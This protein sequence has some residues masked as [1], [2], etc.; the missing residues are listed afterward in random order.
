MSNRTDLAIEAVEALEQGHGIE[1]EEVSLGKTKI[2]TVHIK[3]D[4]DEQK[5]GKRKGKYITI[6]VQPFGENGGFDE[7]TH[8]AIKSEISNIV[9]KKGTVLVVGI[10]NTQITPDAFGPKTA[11]GILATRH[12]SGELAKSVGLEGLRSVAVISPGVLGRTGIESYE[13]IKGIVARIEPA[14]VICIDALAAKSLFRL[15]NTVQI[16]NTGI[17][18]GSGVGNKRAELSRESLGVDVIS[19]GVPTVVDAATIIS[20]FSGNDSNKFRD[21]DLIV[22]PREIDLMNDRAAEMVSFAINCALQPNIDPKILQG[23]V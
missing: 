2:T 14:C 4:S 6:Q 20:E 13:I 18:P 22:T 8:S 1:T 12:I 21:I 10:G 16:S 9:P 5:T 23:L 7:N 17:S 19:V 15:G 3:T 11:D